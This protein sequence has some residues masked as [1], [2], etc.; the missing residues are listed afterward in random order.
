M[1]LYNPT[2]RI[3][4]DF[5][6]VKPAHGEPASK[7]WFLKAVDFGGRT[8]KSFKNRMEMGIEVR[9][10]LDA[11]YAVIDFNTEAE[12]ANPMWGAC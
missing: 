7:E 4:V 10:R 2:T 5:Y 3:M 8:S 11:D 12:V 9:E 1:K 6:P